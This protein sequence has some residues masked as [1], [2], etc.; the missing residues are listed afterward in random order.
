[1]GEEPRTSRSEVDP[2]GTHPDGPREPDEIRADIEA[3]RVE[4]GDTVEAL[5]EKTDVKQQAK[6]RLDDRKAQLKARAGAIR[7]KLGNASPDQAQQGAGQVA[8]H[9]RRQPLPYAAA[10][11]FAAGLVA[12]ILIKRS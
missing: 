2:E 11:A 5:A 3:T 9:A 7:E 8:D 4:L 1:V 6:T 12:G 10:G